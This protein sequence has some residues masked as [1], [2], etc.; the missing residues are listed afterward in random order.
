MNID[1]NFD[2]EQVIN[3]Y[4]QKYALEEYQDDKNLQKN[5]IMVK[6]QANLG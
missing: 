6:Y 5:I 4:V 1:E 3:Y 2:F